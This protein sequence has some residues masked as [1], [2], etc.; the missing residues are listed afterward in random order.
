MNKKMIAVAVAGAL[1][2]PGLA[3]ALM[4][5]LPGYRT[6]LFDSAKAFLQAVA[7]GWLG[8]VIADL[9]LPG[10]ERTRAGKSA[11]AVGGE[12]RNTKF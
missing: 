1:T 12:N 3:L 2:A 11:R 10:E 8:C 9:R 7:E 4:L 6:V 5:G